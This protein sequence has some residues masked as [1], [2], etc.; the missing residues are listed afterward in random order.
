MITS[1]PL[2]ENEQFSPAV[3]P[4][5]P[6]HGKDVREFEQLIDRVAAAIGPVWPLQDYV[7]VNPFAGLTG[8]SFLETRAFLRKFSEIDM[9]M[10]ISHYAKLYST[11]ELTVEAIE[12]AVAEQPRAGRQRGLST[13]EVIVLLKGVDWDSA[14]EQEPTLRMRTVAELVSQ[15]GKFDWTESIRD[16]VGKF[17]AAYYDDGQAIWGTAAKHLPVFQAWRQTAVHD[18]TLEILGITGLRQFI[19]E[20][21]HTPAVTILGCLKKLGVP[22]QRW[23][24]FLLCQVYS[25]PGWSSWAKYQTEWKDSDNREDHFLSL[26]AIRL[27]YDTALA[28]SVPL[29]IQ[30][31]SFPD[32]EASDRDT[33]LRTLLLRATEIAFRDRLLGQIQKSIPVKE[34]RSTVNV[35]MAFCI[36]VRSERMRRALETVSE[37]IET[38]GFAGFF[39]MPIEYV[40]LGHSCGQS[41]VPVLLKPQMRIQ[42][43]LH[44]LDQDEE[45]QSILTRKRTRSW[46]KLWKGLQGSATGCFSFV[47]SCG[48]WFGVRLAKHSAGG[49]SGWSLSAQDGVDGDD[50]GIFGPTLRGLKSQGYAIPQ[51]ADLVEGMLRNIGMTEKFSRLIVFCGHTSRTEN[52][53]LAASLDCGACGGHS[54]EPNARLAALL[55]NQMGVREALRERGI[56]I[57]EETHFLAAVH[58]TTTDQ[59]ELQDLRL[60][61]GSHRKDVEELQG[62]LKAATRISQSERMPSVDCDSVS[63][64][65]KKARD[66]SEVRPEWGLAANAAFVIGPRS[67]TKGVALDGRVFLH[68]YNSSSDVDGSILKSIMTAPMIVAHWINM[69]YYASTVDHQYF[70]SGT[71]TLHNVVGRF[72]ILSGNG[73]DLRT[74]LPWQSLHNGEKLQHLPLRLQVVIAASRNRIQAVLDED[75]AVAELLDGN[76]LDVTALEHNSFYQYT[77]QGRWD[78]I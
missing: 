75:P 41:H 14:M 60:V 29:C 13:G 52:N 65:M 67:L 45:D 2:S 56:E 21:P 32:P 30:W 1:A 58:N 40:P 3:L 44:P 64:L 5:A 28:E 23:E 70:G 4:A 62:A 50:P 66:W 59:I 51:Q 43:G 72:G 35:Q 48:L 63:D 36:D 27:A 11:G 78:S 12:K 69:Q 6:R 61:P 7:A 76:W 24:T 49:L 8:R 42:E 73:G 39:G 31:N 54:G 15:Y 34:S 68:S 10:P 46:R 18:R 20:L 74:G 17:C 37:G 77:G 57:P 22:E 16:E 33:R 47:E 9:L 26:L 25:I 55:L 19:S 71:K 53:P 38:I